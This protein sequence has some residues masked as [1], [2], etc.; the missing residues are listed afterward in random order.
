MAEAEEQNGW[1][2]GATITKGKRR[3]VIRQLRPN[4]V[5]ET[6]KHGMLI[7]PLESFIAQG[8]RVSAAAPLP[9]QSDPGSEAGSE[10]P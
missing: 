10:L 7:M 6:S 3:A 8:W 5:A 1:V 9:Q 4:V 2:I